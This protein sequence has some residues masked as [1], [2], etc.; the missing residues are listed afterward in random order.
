MELTVK[1]AKVLARMEGADEEVCVVAAY[2]HDIG[3]R[4]AKGKHGPRGAK[5][6]RAFLKKLGLPEAFIR[7]VWYAVALHDSGPPKRTKEAAVL[8][9]A[10][11][12][13]SIGPYGFIRIFAHH[14]W[15]D[16]K[17]IHLAR[18]LT[19]SRHTFF[20]KRFHTKSGRAL[21]KRL[22]TF[23]DTF[24]DLLQSVKAAKIERILR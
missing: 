12:L 10:D 14:L 20:F 9:D 5:M 19:A 3:R 1:I 22:H 21:A 11:K 24:Y 6:A 17:D 4:G 7:S 8:W 2:L 23:M 15:Y 18:R 16:T 13:Q